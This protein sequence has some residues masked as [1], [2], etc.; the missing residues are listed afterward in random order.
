MSWFG[1]STTPT[2]NMQLVDN[3]KI[4]MEMMTDLFNK[5]VCVKSSRFLRVPPQDVISVS[6]EMHNIVPRG[7]AEHWRDELC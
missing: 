4:E 1:G 6:Q 7:G 2:Q 5:R 3:A